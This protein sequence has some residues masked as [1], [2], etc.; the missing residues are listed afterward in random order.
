MCGSSGGREFDGP[1]TET[2]CETLTD[3]TT[4][5]SLNPEALDGLKVGDILDVRAEGM[6]A[7]AKI[8]HRA[9]RERCFAAE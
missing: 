3:N 6:S 8:G 5:N 4:L 9:P 7:G 2:N 1:A